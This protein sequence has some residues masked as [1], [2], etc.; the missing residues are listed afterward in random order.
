MKAVLGIAAA[1]LALAGSASAQDH[2]GHKMAVA[3][4]CTDVTLACADKATPFFAGNGA[5]WLAWSANGRVAVVHS[6]DQGRTFAPPVFINHHAEK[7]DGGADTRPQIVVDKAGI[8]TVAYT[9]AKD[10]NYSGQVLTARA[11]NGKEFSPPQPL[12]LS[13]ASQRFVTFTLAP[14]GKVFAAWIDK[15]NLAAA[16]KAGK[17]YAGAALAFSWAEAGNN[18]AVARIAKDNTCECCRIGVTFTGSG[19]PAI[20]W[21]NMFANGVRDHAVMTFADAMTPGPVHRVSVDDWQIDAC[22]HHGPSLAVAPDGAYH[23]AWYTD[24]KARQGLFY[25]RSTDAGRTFSTPMA[26]GDN[27]RQPSRPFVLAAAGRLWLAWKEFDGEQSTVNLMTS[28]DGGVNWSTVKTVA[29]TAEASDHPLLVS[30]GRHVFLSW[31]THNEG[32]RMTAL[33]DGP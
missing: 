22:P 29:R 8:V 15:R 30:D 11:L 28:R 3:T 2:A 23:A 26:I 5:L 20:I 17:D 25:A 24:G 16:Q 7:L 31:L 14:D 10:A 4:A 27:D 19:K 12:T 18:F 32:Y 1:L 21:R 13:D 6:T 9:I 33:E